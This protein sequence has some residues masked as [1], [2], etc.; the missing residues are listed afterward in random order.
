MAE[1]QRAM[2]RDTNLVK[3]QLLWL[4]KGNQRLHR[5]LRG[6]EVAATGRRAAVADVGEAVPRNLLNAPI[7]SV[8]DLDEVHM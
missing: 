1:G 3:R 6:A 2:Q 8:A 5:R 4:I 7:A